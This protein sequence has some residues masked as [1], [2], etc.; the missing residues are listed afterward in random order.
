MVAG[1]YLLFFLLFGLFINFD[2]YLRIVFDNIGN[3]SFGQNLF[4]K[5]VRF[6]SIGVWRIACT[7]IMSF[8]ERQEPGVFARKFGTK[9]HFGIINGKVDHTA[10]ETEKQLS[11]IA[12]KLILFDCIFHI[13]LGQ[14]I[15]EFT[16]DN[17]QT[18][19]KNTEIKGKFRVVI[20]VS[21]LPGNAENVLSKEF[22]RLLVLF[23]RSHIEHYQRSRINGNT[24]AQHIN[25]AAFGDFALQ[26][27]KELFAL[28][29][30][31]IDLQLG[32]FLRLSGIEKTEQA[33]FINGIILVILVGK[34]LFI[35][36]LIP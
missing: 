1:E 15:F 34:P 14:L 21:H 27:V 13:L 29:F 25:N 4:P 2:H 11:G 6:E 33:D 30:A 32:H 7:I 19:D 36:I 8:I 9:T 20:G 5:I 10:F 22:C 16:S 28:D 17:R 24:L 26:T 23:R 18:V 35:S 31:G 12:V 3:G